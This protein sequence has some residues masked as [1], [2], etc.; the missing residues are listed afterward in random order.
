[1]IGPGE[2]KTSRLPLKGKRIYLRE[3]RLSDVNEN[4]LRWVNDPDVIQYL[5]VR[6]NPPRSIESL[7]EFV[8]RVSNDKDTVFMAIV[9]NKNDMHIGNIKLG[10]INRQHRLAEVGLL[11][12]EKGYWGKGYATEAISLMVQYAFN[13]FKL[14]KLTSGCY[15]LN[16]GSIKVFQ[17][18]GFEIE[19]IREKHCLYNDRYTDVKLFGLINTYEADD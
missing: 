12:G 7:K 1:M 2:K 8:K 4:Y 6:H 3:I 11:I 15:A 19:G 9:L 5:E 17:K 13:T 18:N 10:P 14:H 16:K